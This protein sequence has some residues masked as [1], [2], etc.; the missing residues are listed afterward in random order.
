MARRFRAETVAR[1][2]CDRQLQKASAILAQTALASEAHILLSL[3]HEAPI[4]GQ[5]PAAALFDHSAVRHALQR[6]VVADKSG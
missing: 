2:A 5:Y 6:R 4:S 3:E 1:S